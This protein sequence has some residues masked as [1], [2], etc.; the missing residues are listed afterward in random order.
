MHGPPGLANPSEYTAVGTRD[1]RVFFGTPALILVAGILG[2][3]P[4]V[5]PWLVLVWHWE[6]PTS[7]RSLLMVYWAVV[8]N[9]S[10][11]WYEANVKPVREQLNP[12]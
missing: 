10:V 4:T 8:W 9:I 1:S 12:F 3:Q 11:Y 6:F 2:C 5:P 7:V